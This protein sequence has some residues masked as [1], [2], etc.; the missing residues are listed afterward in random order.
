M[1]GGFN[2]EKKDDIV[3]LF[4]FFLSHR[5]ERQKSESDHKKAKLP[6]F[7]NGG[8][9]VESLLWGLPSAVGLLRKR[10]EKKEAC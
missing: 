4:T 5:P 8:E 1:P 6:R 7:D 9:E 10:S 3:N 2:E